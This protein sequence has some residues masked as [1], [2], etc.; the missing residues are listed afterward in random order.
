MKQSPR[1]MRAIVDQL[2]LAVCIFRKRQLVYSNSA[3]QQ[4]AGHVLLQQQQEFSDFVHLHVWRRQNRTCLGETVQQ[5]RPGE[6]IRRPE[7]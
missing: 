4:L 6:D 7:R 5:D 2:P 1:V 3:A